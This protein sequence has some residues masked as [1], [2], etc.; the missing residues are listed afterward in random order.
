MSRSTVL[1]RRIKADAPTKN[2]Y[3]YPAAARK[4]LRPSFRKGQDKRCFAAPL[5]NSPCKLN[6]YREQAQ[7]LL[8]CFYYGASTPG[9]RGDDME[10][11]ERLAEEML[12]RF[13]QHHPTLVVEGTQGKFIISFKDFPDTQEKKVQTLANAGVR[14]GA[15]GKVGDLCTLY[16]VFEA[17]MSEAKKGKL[18]VN[19]PSADPNR[20]EVLIINGYDVATK[21]HELRV[22]EMMRDKRSELI[23]LQ[24]FT[25]PEEGTIESPL[26]PAFVK[27]FEMISRQ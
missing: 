6:K 16:F 21:K 8:P 20:K 23:E 18:P 4:G 26:L 14:V 27:G 11:I 7:A 10:E 25:Q 3:F 22:L 19:P 1:R 13:G 15:E 5:Q 17:W 9:E 2:G 12:V 24:P